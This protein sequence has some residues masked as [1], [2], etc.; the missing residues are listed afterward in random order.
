MKRTPRKR[1]TKKLKRTAFKRK[2]GSLDATLKKYHGFAKRKKPMGPGKVKLEKNLNIAWAMAHYFNEHGWDH[3]GERIAFDQ[4]TGAWLSVDEAHAHHKTP[5]SEARKLG[6]K[7]LDAPEK[8]IICGY[9]AHL[10]WVHGGHGHMGRPEPCFDWLVLTE[11]DAK[12]Q[13]F[14]KHAAYAHFSIVENSPA[15]ASNNL[16][17]EWGDQDRHDLDRLLGVE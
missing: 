1:G 2:P 5:R 15:N 16:M 8:L 13:A 10:I 14:K 6:E 3:D 9:R 12:A 7:D 11:A 17:V 4:I